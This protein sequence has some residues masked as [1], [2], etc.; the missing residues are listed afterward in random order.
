MLR[1]A[2]SHPPLWRTPTSVQLGPDAAARI[3]DIAPWQERMLAALTGGIADALLVPLAVEYGATGG[4]ARAFLEAVRPA[5][6]TPPTHTA[7]R[8]DLPV[9]LP[10]HEADAVR[11]G[12]LAAG[13]TIVPARSPAP[14]VL[15]AHRIA[16]PHRAAG[17]T[18]DDVPHLPVVLAGD[19]ATVGPLVVPGETACLACENAH[20]RDADALWPQIAAQL[21]GRPPVRSDP[22]VLA[23]AAVLAGR[24]LAEGRTGV[25]ATVS[26]ASARRVW[27]AHRPHAACLC[28]RPQ[29]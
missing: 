24:L 10:A 14:V 28:R 11:D 8:L 18:A 27:H 19:A 2:D 20:R 29:A 1:L 3:D 6:R 5:L 12:I 22:A 16:P 4:E 9:D 26:T 25:S 15:V 17:L 13:L 7:A 21:L 23:E